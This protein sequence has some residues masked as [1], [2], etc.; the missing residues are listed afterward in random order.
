M[1]FSDLRK[2]SGGFG[3]SLA[4]LVMANLI[5]LFGVVFLGWG[6][7]TVLMLF[8]LEALV[9]GV[10][11]LIKIFISYTSSSS[12]GK[13]ALVIMVFYFLHFSVFI[14][15]YTL[16][17]INLFA[18]PEYEHIF[19][20]MNIGD[21]FEKLL[22]EM[23]LKWA[24]AALVFSNVVSLVFVY[25]GGR[26]YQ[27]ADPAELMFVPYK[28]LFSIHFGFLIG[29]HIAV[30]FGMTTMPFLS[31]LLILKTAMDLR[32]YFKEQDKMH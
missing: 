28:Y 32:W 18:P 31:V 14:T 1:A 2:Y 17:L 22:I 23:E 20:S 25:I 26:E 8:C 30:I 29:A 19:Y 13:I 15:V 9:V 10:T 11:Y 27:K 3:L 4:A 6:L 5:P 7:I 12:Q 24:F 21:L 16:I